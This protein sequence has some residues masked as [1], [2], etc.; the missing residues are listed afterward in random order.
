MLKRISQLIKQNLRAKNNNQQFILD[1][2]SSNTAGMPL[3]LQELEPRIMFD[4]AA[5]AT[6]DLA[7]DVSIKE[8]AYVLDAFAQNEHAKVTESLLDAIKADSSS[9]SAN[10]SQFTE[11]VII[12]A[13]VKDPHVIINSISRDAAVEVILAEDDG[14]EA[15]AKVLEKYQHL[16]ALHIIS[17]GD[18]AKLQLGGTELNSANIAEYQ[19]QLQQWGQALNDSGDI[20]FY[21]CNV[22]QGVKGQAFVEQLKEYTLA[23]IAASDDI[24]GVRYT[25]GQQVDSELE[26]NDNV[27]SSSIVHFQEYAYVLSSSEITQIGQDIVGEN[28][29]DYS[30]NAL[31]YSSDG[32]RVAIGAYGNDDNGSDAG[33]VRVYEFDGSSWLQLGSDLDGLN[34]GDSYGN[35]VSLSDDGSRLIIGAYREGKGVSR[36]YEW[37]GSD[38]SQIGNDIESINTAGNQHDNAY[39]VAI[40]ADGSRIIVSDTG[41]VN[42]N[43]YRGS[44]RV[45]EYDG[46]SNWVQ[47]GSMISGENNGD[48][49]GQAIAINT[50]GDIIAIGTDWNDDSA[51]NAGHVRLY[52]WDG[53]DWQQL[54]V[55]ID[56]SIAND[57]IG[58]A[59]SL[60]SDGLR[61]AIGGQQSVDAGSSAGKVVVYDYDGSNWVVAGS[62]LTG[63]SG[64]FYGGS[65]SLSADGHRLAVGAS[66]A[67]SGGVVTIYDWDVTTQN[68]WL[69]GDFIQGDNDEWLGENVQL[70]AAGDKVAV[71]APKSDS[72]SGVTR[73]Y[74]LQNAVNHVPKA[75]NRII[76]L[77]E[78]STYIFKAEDFGFSDSDGDSLSSIEVTSLPVNGALKLAGVSI[79]QNQIIAAVDIGSMTFMPSSNDSGINYANFNFKVND[80]ELDSI[81]EYVIQFDVNS[82]NDEASQIDFI[83]TT[84]DLAENV[85]TSSRIHIA[86]IMVIDDELGNN[87]LTLSGLDAASFELDGSAVYLKAGVVLNYEQQSSYIFDVSVDDLSISGNPNVLESYNLSI[88]NINEEPDGMALANIVSLLPETT[89]T[90]SRIKLAD[91]ILQGDSIGT[92]SYTLTGID[93]SSFEIDN[94]ELYLKSGVSLDYVTKSTYFITINVDDSEIVGNANVYM[95]FQL[96]IEDSRIFIIESLGQA[97][98][99]ENAYDYSGDALAYSSDGTRVAIGAYGNDDN[100][101]DAGHVRVYEFD[102]S[103]WLQLGSDLDGLNAGDS[104]GNSVSLSDDGSRLII[105]AYREGKG[106][107]RVYEWNGSD[108]S[109]IGNDIESIIT[110]GN[111]H[112][113]AY[114]VAINADGSRII[115]SDTGSVNT[116]DYRGSV[117]VF[118]YDGVSNWVQMGS[119]I[120][121]ENNSDRSGQA[122]AINTVGDIIAIGTDWNDDSANN[123]GHVRLYQWDGND[124]QQLGVDIDGSIANDRIG[125]ALSLSSDGLR[126][127][128]G[129]QQS[130]D[131]GSS[132]GKVVV[133]DY[134]GSNWVVAGSKLTGQSGDFYGESV[135]LSADGHRLAV[136]ASR[137]GSGGVVTIYDWDH[138]L[139]DWV[140]LPESI[141][142]SSN[143]WLGSE[144]VISADGNKV[145]IGSSRY[146]GSGYN[147]GKVGVYTL[148]HNHPPTAVNN[149]VVTNEDSDYTFS[150]NE[151]N[152]SDIDGD[153]FASI[154]ITVLETVGSLKLN[155]A[156]VALNQVI[157]K[158][159]IDAGYLKFT[160]VANGNG[161]PYTS[162]GFSVNDGTTDSIS[163]YT[164]TVDVTAV[165]DAPVNTVPGAQSVAEDDSLAINGISVTDVDGNLASTRLQVTNG[166]LTIS[167]SGSATISS[168]ANGSNDL[169]ISGNETD[170]NA[171]LASLSY[172]GNLHFNG[173]DT[174]SITS[175]DSDGTPLTD[176]DTVDITVTAVNDAPVNTVPAA[177]SVAEDDILTISG[178]SVTDVDGNLASTRLQVT[179]GVLTISLSGSATISSGANGSNDLT[180]SG[181]ETDINATLASLS[182][183]GNVNFNG[184]DTLSITSTDSDGIPLTDVDTVTITVT[185]VNDVPVVSAGNTLAYSENDAATVIDGTIS[186]SDVD[187]VNLTTATVTLTNYVN[188]EDVLSFVDTVNISGSF[189]AITGVLTLTGVDSVANYEAALQAVMYHNTSE[190]PDETTRSVAFVV[191]DGVDDS[192]I[193]TSTITINAVNDA[194]VVS[195]GNTLAYSENDSATVID[196][197]IS[198]IDVDSVNL[199]TATISLSNY[200]N[201]EDVLSFVNTVNISGSFDAITGVLT[202]TGVDSVANYEAALQAVMYHNTSET[203]DETTRSVAFVVNDG[204]DDSNIATSTI[205]INA[206]NDAPVNTVPGAQTVAEDDS[207]AISGISVTDVD[208][209]LAST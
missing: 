50:V 158:A 28:T 80:G 16:D 171:T 196:G 97:L 186:L 113:N 128:I 52:Q 189:D 116:N 149:T 27:E 32:T 147:I 76:V 104:Y 96:S 188:G 68:W 117:R 1:D 89:D 18:Q 126:V 181:N 102:G 88:L 3:L 47:M 162:F 37:N 184:S 185:A 24:T 173:N 84:A 2:L 127:A 132:A 31:A 87:E 105:G 14:V 46:V 141:N 177:Q 92:N 122:I 93:A 6:V 44:V 4:G 54:G 7:D 125:S 111:Q 205:T 146:S 153:V 40:N 25:K 56:G 167:L 19:Q 161:L 200:V 71:A 110:A 20:L 65:V 5:F 180:I 193:A 164:L 22:A 9:V 70:N 15:I 175:T 178:I 103:S 29:Y 39:A 195:A 160:P 91:I 49:S 121:G 129:G 140:L 169:T 81:N 133:Y 83:N 208:G 143:E 34:A 207:L 206:V 67:G 183:Q 8:Q 106:V 99:G 131:A 155:S 64:D 201:G 204:V 182:Y 98:I 134:D 130:V 60:S 69:I 166:V 85:D 86:D 124:W 90:G 45:F 138:T 57:R 30:G 42:I 187:S 51:N 190:T 168:G 157:S 115:V 23:D 75:S 203:P 17:H 156:D 35:S 41:S 107:S 191:N 119:M 26:S 139:S 136:G 192:N 144:V 148:S 12:D 79:V 72:S 108:W 165:N 198:L 11:V 151:F 36:V 13:R 199:T 159:D 74:D 202:L 66:R 59:L 154:K 100:G 53:N 135:S 150:A 176:V 179:N 94:A 109:Q 152:Y 58:S 197:T 82:I 174:L 112:D 163:S 123:A 95:D 137:A 120:S 172:Q 62:K 114:A 55:D 170:I 10:Y 33:H 142:G 43:D 145:A 48:Q 63:Q 194:P 77:D 118:E 101:S 61:V 21:G 38:W 209:N 73:I 78:D